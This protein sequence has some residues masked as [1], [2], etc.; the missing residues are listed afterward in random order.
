MCIRDSLMNN[1]DRMKL[2][3]AEENHAQAL[4][5]E[6]LRLIAEDKQLCASI[7]EAGK[8]RT[9]LDGLHFYLFPT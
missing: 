9:V 8:K 2:A 1:L 6:A 7:A 5:E 4:E 3:L